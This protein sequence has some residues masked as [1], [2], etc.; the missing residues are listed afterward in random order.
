M[1]YEISTVFDSE[2]E[3]AARHLQRMIQGI[4]PF[5]VDNLEVRTT[6]L[7]GTSCPRCAS[8][9]RGL[10]GRLS[11][12]DEETRLCRSPWHYEPNRCPRCDS[13]DPRLH[14]AMQHEGEVQLC[15][16]SWHTQQSPS[17]A[18]T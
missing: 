11:G 18:T 9:C 15:P 6:L 16:H 5:M 17:G 12:Q 4:A 1:R 14:P 2:G 8:R 10:H 13:H 7:P 3:A